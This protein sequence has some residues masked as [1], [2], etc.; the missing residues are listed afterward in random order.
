MPCESVPHL[1]A[2]PYFPKSTASHL[3]TSNMAEG[4]PPYNEGPQRDLKLPM[5]SQGL[6]GW[7]R[8]LPARGTSTSLWLDA[9]FQSGSGYKVHLSGQRGP[10]RGPERGLCQA[11]RTLQ[12]RRSLQARRPLQ[13][14]RGNTIP[15]ISHKLMCLNSTLVGFIRANDLFFI[16]KKRAQELR[17]P[18]LPSSPALLILNFKNS[19]IFSFNFI[20]TVL[21][22]FFM[23]N[24]RLV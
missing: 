10:L 24:S 17:P 15:K 22:S 6:C 23:F 18:S 4:P 21:K 20:K 12:S 8:P 2:L 9:G 19:P 16:A 7:R 14:R 11:S 1:R 5:L 13:A 3:D